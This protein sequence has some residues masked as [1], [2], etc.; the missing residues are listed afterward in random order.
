M[1]APG[2]VKVFGRRGRLGSAKRE[3]REAGY[4][5]NT[6]KRQHP[7]AGAGRGLLRLR[8]R[9]PNKDAWLALPPYLGRS[10]RLTDNAHLDRLAEAVADE[11]RQRGLPAPDG[12]TQAG[13]SPKRTPAKAARAR[14]D[15]ATTVTAGQGPL[16][17][18]AFNTG[19]RHTATAKEFRVSRSTVQDVI[20]DAKRDSRRTER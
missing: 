6:G 7:A 14:P 17:L 20:T 12:P 2:A 18:A 9:P 5:P 19:L 11:G 1:L 15:R 3:H 10:L 8:S 4:V 13:R 16:I